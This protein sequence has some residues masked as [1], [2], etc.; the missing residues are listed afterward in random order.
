M[1][2]KFKGMA[3]QFKLMQK[4]MKDEDFRSFMQ[5][6]KVQETFKDPEFQEM[7]RSKDQAQIMGNP[8]MK[9]LMSD[10]EVLQLMSKVNFQDLMQS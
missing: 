1:L 3:D 2:D 9:I 8:K 4:L 7:I 6:P 5:H 10:P